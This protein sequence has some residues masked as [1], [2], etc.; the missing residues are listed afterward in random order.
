[1]KPIPLFLFK[2]KM[3][4]HALICLLIKSIEMKSASLFS[5]SD[6]MKTHTLI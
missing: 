4:T 1:M 2:Q 5:F 3:K 6:K